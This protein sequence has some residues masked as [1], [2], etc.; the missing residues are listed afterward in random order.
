[1]PTDADFLDAIKTEAWGR[2]LPTVRLARLIAGDE[3]ALVEPCTPCGTSGDVQ[4]DAERAALL[5]A[6]E[7]VKALEARA[8]H[9]EH[10]LGC[11]DAAW[12]HGAGELRRMAR[13]A[14]SPSGASET[15]GEG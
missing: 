5:D 11:I 9:L 7:R 3:A 14:L 10:R 6:R 12:G 8:K 15:E 1:M 4:V 2:D 13:A